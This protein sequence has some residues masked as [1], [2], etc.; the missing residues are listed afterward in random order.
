MDLTIDQASL[1]RALKLA[2][3]VAPAGGA[4]P[5]LQRVLLTAEPGRLTVSACDLDIA[6]IAGLAAGVATPGQAVVGAHLLAD[7][8]AQLPA[9][10]VRLRG[11]EARGR[12][13]V[14]CERATA[15]FAA[16]D[17]DDFPVLPDEAEGGMEFDA[18][19]LARALGRVLSAAAREHAGIPALTAVSFALDDDEL[20]LAACDGFRLARA[21][22]VPDGAGADEPRQLLVPQRGAAEMARLL[23]GAG[24][25]AAVARLAPTADER[26]VWLS[27]G[28]TALY[29]RLQGGAFPAIDPLIPREWGTSVTVGAAPLR[30]A[31]RLGTLFGDGE[32]RPVLLD[33]ADGRLRALTP[34]GEEGHAET[35][36]TDVT[37]EGADGAIMVDARLLAGLL[38][39]AP[40]TSWLTLTWSSPDAALTVRERGAIHDADC[41][42][43]MPLQFDSRLHERAVATRDAA[44]DGALGATA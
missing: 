13:R 11:G 19:T 30:D 17:P 41:W 37:V 20:T 44:A 33:A 4:M 25:D 35:A 2:A 14:E 23:A 26:G 3:R 10:I 38:D 7:Y 31:L 27:L 34:E 15:Q 16:A 29:A 5:I 40:R 28:D 1:A 8:V 43:L 12:L 6:A 9:T 24:T 22:A 18:A 21:R 39:A 36:L 32:L 42:L